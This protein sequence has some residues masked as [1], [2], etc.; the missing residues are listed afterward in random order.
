MPPRLVSSFPRAVWRSLRC[1]RIEVNFMNEMDANKPIL[2]HH[3]IAIW[4]LLVMPLS[5]FEFPGVHN[6]FVIIINVASNMYQSLNTIVF[7]I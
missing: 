2:N 5:R 6:D 7:D 4:D 3:R 1:D